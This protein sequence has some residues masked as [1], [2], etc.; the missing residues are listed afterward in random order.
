MTEEMKLTTGKLL[1]MA[2]HLVNTF[3]KDVPVCMPDPLVTDRPSFTD[4]IWSVMG[5]KP[6]NTLLALL[7]P[8][9]DLAAIETPD[10]KAVKVLDVDELAMD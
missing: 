1:E 7:I 5:R 10:G 9:A 8:H 2:Q 4:R 3:G 6:D